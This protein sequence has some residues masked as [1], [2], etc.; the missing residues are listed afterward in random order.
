MFVFDSIGIRVTPRVIDSRF[1]CA[2]YTDTQQNSVPCT[3]AY[4]TDEVTSLSTIEEHAR[5]VP[6]E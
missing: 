1:C 3:R 6:A 2:Y 5:S 4:P